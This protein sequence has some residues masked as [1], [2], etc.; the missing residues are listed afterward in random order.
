[1]RYLGMSLGMGVALGYCA[2]FGTLLPP[3]GKLFLPSVPVPETIAQIAA[4]VPGQVTLA[5]GLR[6]PARHRHRRARWPDQGTGNAGGGEESRRGRVQFPQGSA[7]GDVFGHPE[8]VFF[9][10]ADGGESHW[11]RLGGGGHVDALDRVA[12]ARR[13]AAGRVHHELPLVRAAQPQEP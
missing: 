7:G 5:G 4:T 8:R 13:G 12:Q 10:R 2:A 9:L 6:V 3:I 11:G 1:M